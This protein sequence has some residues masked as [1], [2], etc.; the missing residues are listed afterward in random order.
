MDYQAEVYGK[1]GKAHLALKVHASADGSQKAR[2]AVSDAL[3]R[4]HFLDNALAEGLLVLDPVTWGVLDAGTTK[5][6]II[7]R[8]WQA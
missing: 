6:K 5:R 7:D 8:R 4:A 2:G 3:R 1:G